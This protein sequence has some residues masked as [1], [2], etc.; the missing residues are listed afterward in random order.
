MRA[1]MTGLCIAGALLLGSSAVGAEER[2]ALVVGQSDY[3]SLSKLANPVPDA[4][5]IAAALREHGFQVTEHY[6]L[7]RAELL[8]ALEAFTSTADQAEV[9]LVYYAGHGMEIAGRNVLAPKD[10]E[11]D[12]EKK[13]PRR[14]IDL[15]QIFA[16]ISGAP[17]Q[18]VLLDACRNDPFPQCP[19][20]SAGTGSGFRGFARV[21]A[22]GR[23]LLVANAT[24]SGQ[25]AADGDPGAHS[26]FAGALLARFSSD[27]RAYLRD[28]L[29][30]TAADVSKSSRG[31]QVPEILTRGG[32]PR[33]CLDRENCGGAGSA[34]ARAESATTAPPRP[35][36]LDQ[37]ARGWADVQST[38]SAAVLEAF[39]REFPDG[40]YAEL[41]RAKLENLKR[42][43]AVPPRD[44][45]DR[46]AAVEQGESDGHS[47]GVP[48]LVRSFGPF[49]HDVVSVAFSPDGK[50]IYA[51]L[52]GGY[53]MKLDPASGE[54]GAELG[55]VE[56]RACCRLV[57]S[58][59][60][61]HLASGNYDNLVLLWDAETGE[62]LRSFNGHADYVS[63]VA[64]SPDGKLIVS[65]SY[66]GTIR[67]WDAESGKQLRSLDP[68]AGKVYSIAFSPDG[69]LIA[70]GHVDGDI[71]VWD[72]A[73]GRPLNSEKA[74]DYGVY[75]L[76]FS[77]DGSRLL[78]TGADAK[79]RVWDLAAKKELTSFGEGYSSL[80]CVAI[81]PDGRTAA[82]GGSD[83]LVRLWDVA[84]GS[85][86][87]T[88]EHSDWIQ[89]VLF[90][91]DGSQLAS[92]ANDKTVKLWDM[93]GAKAAAR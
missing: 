87:D 73:N 92:G 29:D 9:A 43:G 22:E 63:S 68:R 82:A 50:R 61:K 53:F 60:G 35:S 36:S 80:C 75:F 39:L 23:S 34:E 31:A 30:L 72:A 74:N 24:L 41:A 2:V 26:P 8:D 10:M 67:I 37:A 69:K 77:P 85:L 42:A 47:S 71:K 58:P 55:L 15:D 16:A 88:L 64:F 65:G 49:Q 4:K 28:L 66:D 33:I 32:A 89:T 13:T 90:S 12:C 52:S 46:V 19:S 57:V 40:F 11:I 91:P 79:V 78:S 56:H 45:E 59:D 70:S 25:L 44:A 81:S 20:R 86:L 54:V 93:G 84:S 1:I 21:T 5:A 3:Q 6:D 7:P 83:N 51:L 17:S 38:E 14:A 48:S 76:V 18:I 27:S 62:Q